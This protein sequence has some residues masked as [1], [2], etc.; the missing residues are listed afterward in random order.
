LL[1]GFKGN[2]NG[3]GMRKKRQH[4]VPQRYLK[5]FSTKKNIS[6]KEEC[7]YVYPFKTSECYI[8]NVKDLC[9]EDFF[10]GEDERSQR[11]ED[12]LGKFEKRQAKIIRKIIENISIDI[13]NEDEYFEFI[14]FL[15][16]Q[17]ARTKRS[18]WEIK[19]FTQMM[20]ENVFKPQLKTKERPPNIPEDFID[21]LKIQLPGDFAL[22]MMGAIC[23]VEGLKDLKAV[24]INNITNQNF[25]CSDHPVVRY[26][27]IKFENTS[28]IDY[29]APG[30][31][32]FYPINNEIT[33]MLF[34][35]KAYSVDR[36]FD[37]IYCL[38]NK[39]DLESINKLQFIS[40]VDHILFSDAH[41]TENVKRIHRNVS[42]YMGHDYHIDK[43]EDIHADG[44]K[45]LVLRHR[46][47]KPR[48]ILDLSFVS[49]YRGYAE[50]CKEIFEKTTKNNP[51]AKPIRDLKLAAKVEECLRTKEEQVKEI[52]E[53][54]QGKFFTIA[55]PHLTP[56]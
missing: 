54:N 53:K 52:M 15:L 41:E 16:I 18:K 29:L 46:P 47:D 36:D 32:I 50:Y 40:A 20:V 39:N 9:K 6:N 8:S 42:E 3:A 26:N 22:R 2:F 25:Y 48:Y 10:Y 27:Y 33:I 44:S 51:K 28:S 4:F 38:N 43:T 12:N 7:L 21:N 49:F 11:F 37:S 14:L 19:E 56:K 17:D 23:Y 1:Y 24:L 55:T 31:I 13:L 45:T 35:E 30:L 34:D 5:N